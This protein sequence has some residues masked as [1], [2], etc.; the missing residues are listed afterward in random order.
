MREIDTGET[1]GGRR[2]RGGRGL[3]PWAVAAAPESLE[4]LSGLRM[5]VTPW[6][7][8]VKAQQCDKRA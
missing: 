6:K 8:I 4:D 1:E 2:R 7:V 3:D 5:K